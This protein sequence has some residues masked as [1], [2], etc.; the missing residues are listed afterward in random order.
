MAKKVEEE[1]VEVTNVEVKTAPA[2]DTIVGKIHS[3]LYIAK[4]LMINRMG[5]NWK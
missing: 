5:R 2:P 3:Q 1:K 4:C